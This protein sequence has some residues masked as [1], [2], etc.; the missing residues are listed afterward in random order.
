M[1]GDLPSDPELAHWAELLEE[2]RWAAFLVDRDSRL[3][4]VSPDLLRFMGSPPEDELGYGLHVLE[5]FS[6]QP[7]QR[8]ATVESRTGLLADLAPVVMGVTSEGDVDLDS[9]SE[10]V[11]AL[12][13][14]VE[15]RPFTRPIATSFDYL[16]PGSDIELPVMRVNVLA[17]PIRSEDGDLIGAVAIG[18]AGLRPGLVSLL[19]RGEEEMYERMAKL[20]EP[21]S[22]QGAIL[23]CDLEGST[24][25]ARELPTAQYFRLI[26]SLWTEIDALVA[27]HKGIVGKHAGDGATAFFLVDDLGTPSEVATAAIRAARGIHERSE[28]VF[29]DA[30]N[31]PCLMRVGVHWGSSIYI[32]QL[33]PGGRLD[34]TALGDAVNECARIQECA[35]PHETLASKELVE[36]LSDDDKAALGIDPEKVRYRPVSQIPN[37]SEKAAAAAGAIPVTTL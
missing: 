18:Y 16:E 22:R 5:A 24:E 27:S 34:V 11:S 12:V 10:W 33:V 20:V 15:P 26:R 9:V 14:E 7:W 23:F 4:W 31:A 6:Q 36:R 13:Q 30:L 29:G 19:A 28:E 25:L 2:L 1:A 35:D 8:I 37:V 32:G 17:A 3:V 21:T